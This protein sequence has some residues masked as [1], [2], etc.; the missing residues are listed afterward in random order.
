[1]PSPTLLTVTGTVLLRE[2]IA[3]PAGAVATVK[4][5]DVEG[6]VLA[7][8]AVEVL[9]VP[10]EFTLAV[11]PS[12]IADPAGL[13]IWAMLRTEVGVW[14][15]TDLVPVDGGSTAVMLTKIDG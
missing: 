13:L 9:G 15:T 3:M 8:S 7:A 2:R 1:M 12:F 14:G 6:E 5:V 10:T 4:L 11:D